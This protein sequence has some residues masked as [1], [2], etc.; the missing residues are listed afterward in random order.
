MGR[1][2]RLL[3][4]ANTD[5]FV[6]QF[7]S[8]FLAEHVRAGLEVTAATPAGPH[9][10]RLRRSGLAWQPLPISRGRGSPVSNLATAWG[11]R[12]LARRLQPDLIHL[13]TAKPVLLGALVLP[14]GD[15]PAVVNVLPGLGRPFSSG[16]AL[17]ALERRLVRWG[18]HRALARPRALLITHQPADRQAILGGSP[19]LLPRSRVIPGWGIDVEGFR[20]ARAEARPPLVVMVSRMLWSK[21]VDD[22]VQ[23][24]GRCRAAGEARFALVG[25]PDPG[26]PDRV[27][28][29][30]LE[31]WRAAGAV[32]WWGARDDIPEI[33]AQASLLVLPSRYGEGVPQVLIEAAAAGLPVVATDL[34]GCRA[35]VEDGQN[36]RLAPPG[37]VAGLAQAVRSLLDDEVLRRRMGERGVQLARERFAV[38]A[39]LARYREAYAALGLDWQEG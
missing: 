18:A 19:A 30:Q 4:V 39:I 2:R 33:L 26:H 23:I 9:L 15:G 35:A 29:R 25:A 32:E 31:A 3:V 24:A 27:P 13:V 1:L 38:T 10:E 14:R 36:G 5:W 37:D 12:R 20:R 7:M 11:L 6:A 34:P 28:E 8:A 17:A 16:G 22:F 21:G